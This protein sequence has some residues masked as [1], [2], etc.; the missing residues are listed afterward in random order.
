MSEV[1]IDKKHSPRQPG[2]PEMNEL[3]L[4]SQM[5]CIPVAEK[6]ITT[7]NIIVGCLL[8][9]GLALA[10]CAIAVAGTDTTAVD[11]LWTTLS[12]YAA[13]A[14]GKIIALLSFLS[15]VWFGIVRPNYTNA[16][17]SIMFCLLMANAKDIIEG[18]LTMA[19]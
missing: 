15:A 8:A 10:L 17:G 19:L 11:D 13:G 14:P 4:N 18:F 12:G 16:I 6:K 3:V 9:I 1:D 5:D 7:Q 2:D